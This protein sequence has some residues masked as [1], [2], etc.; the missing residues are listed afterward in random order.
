MNEQPGPQDCAKLKRQLDSARMTLDELEVQAAGIP[1]LERTATFSRN[2]TEQREKVVELER[3]LA[4]CL[5]QET[6]Q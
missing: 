1:E 3:K 5:E 2:L 4:E 6:Q